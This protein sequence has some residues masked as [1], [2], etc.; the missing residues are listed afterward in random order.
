MV[1]PGVPLTNFT[2]FARWAGTSFA[3][4]HVAGRLAT[5]MTSS[6][7]TAIQA[8]QQLLAAPRWRPNYGVYV[9]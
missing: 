1:L 3:A 4:P 6:G 7:Y 9:G 2:G 5:M 8:R